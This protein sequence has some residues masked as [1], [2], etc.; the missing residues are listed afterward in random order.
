MGNYFEDNSIIFRG[1]SVGLSPCPV[2]EKGKPW[3]LDEKIAKLCIE[4]AEEYLD[5]Q[6][7]VITASDFMLY[8][9]TGDR[10][11]FGNEYFK[12]RSALGS[13]LMAE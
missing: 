11:L 1:K 9:E 13:M 8:F 7:R 6:P 4:N 12:R 3:K 2:W 5:W 10:V